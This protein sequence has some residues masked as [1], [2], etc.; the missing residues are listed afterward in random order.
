VTEVKAP[1]DSPVKV[2]TEAPV[3]APTDSPVKAP[4]DAPVKAPT[5]APVKAPTDSPVKAPTDAPVKAFTDA[6]VKA[7]VAIQ[8]CHISWDGPDLDIGIDGAEDIEIIDTSCPTSGYILISMDIS[9]L[10]TLE[11]SGSSKDTLQVFY[12]V[13]DNPEK[14]WLDIAGEQYSSPAQKIITTG[15]QLTIRVVGDTTY[16]NEFY[17]IRNF[18]VT[19]SFSPA[20]TVAPA[21][22]PPGV[23]GTPKVRI[24]FRCSCFS[25][26]SKIIAPIAYDYLECAHA[27]QFVGDWKGGKAYPLNVAEAQG[28]LIGND[29]IIISGFDN[30]WT[31]VTNRNFALDMSNPNAEWR[32]LAVMPVFPEGITHSGYVVIGQKFFMC[33][34]VRPISVNLF[35]T[36]GPSLLIRLFSLSVQYLGGNV[37]VD[38]PTCLVYDHSVQPNGKWSF[39]ENL[40]EGRAGGGMVYDAIKNQLIYAGGTDRPVQ[41]NRQA[42][43]KN[44]TWAYSFD[45]PEAGWQKMADLP[46]LANHMSFVTA[47]DENGKDRHFFLGGQK[48]ENEWTGNVKDNY[49]WDSE[50]EKWIKHTDMIISRGH[51]ASSTQAIGCGY[52]IAGGSSNENGGHTSDISYYD[53][54]TNTWTKIGDLPEAL[55]TPVCVIRDSILHCESGHP[56]SKFSY[57][58]EIALV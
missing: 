26:L 51:A 36:A 15:S 45:D 43:D 44:T 48:G 38:V 21:T 10:G 12:K 18:A 8:T 55:N 22:L 14:L 3:K 31:Q 42:F 27:L 25:S 56:W 41:G 49:E 35:S 4:T 32:E 39:F 6:P 13:D 7:P 52:I 17:Q 28:K 20:P 34:G 54:P 50:G 30:G 24:L 16:S 19:E 23:C 29:F 57:N 40:P 5:D 9:H 58:R 37:G 2:P 47:K 33:G 46:F 1:T 53:I 11:A